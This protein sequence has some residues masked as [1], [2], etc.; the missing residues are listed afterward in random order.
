MQTL[1]VVL[2]IFMRLRLCVCVRAPKY[3]ISQP[4]PPSSQRTLRLRR[5][6]TLRN[7]HFAIFHVFVASLPGE[8]SILY[9]TQNKFLG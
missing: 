4:Q 8:V 1:F 5:Q 7:I 9:G 2:Y 3:K 6:A